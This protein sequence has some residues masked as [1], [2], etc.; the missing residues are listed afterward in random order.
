MDNINSCSQ[1]LQVQ[2]GKTEKMNNRIGN[3]GNIIYAQYTEENDN[4]GLSATTLPRQ[5]L[6]DWY[7][8]TAQQDRKIETELQLKLSLYQICFSPILAEQHFTV[9]ER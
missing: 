6:K 1:E 8:W 4:A 7:K 5:V 9:A 2:T 3:P